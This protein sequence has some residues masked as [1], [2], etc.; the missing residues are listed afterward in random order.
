[1]SL[2][3]K[4]AGYIEMRM[5]GKVKYYRKVGA[6]IGN[7]CRIYTEYFGTEP[8]LIEIGDRVTVTHGVR[9]LTHDGSTWLM[10]DSEGRRYHYAPIKIGNDVFIGVDS[11]IMPSVRIGDKVV[12]AAGSVV[13]KSVPSGVIVAGNPARIIGDYSQ[14]EQ[15]CLRKY[16]SAKELEVF[17]SYDERVSAALSVEWKEELK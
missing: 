5:I 15:R 13:T 11:I 12:V 7:G 14:Y 3:S 16:K 10:R 6:K 17:S 8:F 2:I 4:V 1:M 9:L